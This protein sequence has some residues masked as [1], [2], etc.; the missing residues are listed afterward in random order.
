MDYD[1]VALMEEGAVGGGDGAFGGGDG[2]IGGG[3]E[4]ALCT[5]HG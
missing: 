5:I 4:E 2:A 1:G 3:G